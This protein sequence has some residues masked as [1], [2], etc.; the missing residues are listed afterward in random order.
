MSHVLAIDQ[1][2]SGTKAVLFDTL[3]AVVD[4]ATREHEQIYPQPGWVEHDA[5]AI[6]KNTLA[7]VAEVAERRQASIGDIAGVSI[8]N[9]R[10]T[11]VVF[12]RRTGQPL[13]NAIVWQCRRSDAICRDMIDAGCEQTIRQKTGLRL[14]AYFSASKLKWLLDAEPELRQR[15][16]SGEA[17]FGTIDTYLI[18]RLTRGAVYATD[19]TNASRTLLYDTS[20]LCWSSALCEEFSVP[21][22]R[23]P[24]VRE[25]SAHFGVTDA[26]GVFP[27]PVPICGVMG[28][29]QAALFAQRCFHPGMAKATFGSGTSV[30]LNIGDERPQ[31]S[32]DSLTALATVIDGRP[33]YALEGLINFSAA[34]ISWLKNQLGLIVDAHETERLAGAVEDNG[35][36]YLVPAF[37]G[38][39]APHWSPTAR[40]AIIGLSAHSRKEHVVRAALESI[41]YQVRDVLEMMRTDAGVE[42]Q[43]LFAD[44][45]PTRNGLLMQFVADVA[46]I[47]LAVAEAPEASALGAAMAGMLG[48]GI[49]GSLQELESLPREVRTFCPQ[50]ERGQVD[51]L[52]AGWSTA[53]GRVL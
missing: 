28:D 24:E 52:V 25:S 4:K 41:A 5:E 53:V 42:P 27:Q 6:W 32:S 49:Y 35:G 39:S 38:L 48:L 3:G 2:T 14:D 11:F 17:L 36:V 51:R 43:V 21:R 44:G 33:T 15:I 10:E 31:G 8:S 40:A 1:S 13:H 7:V 23:L 37:A 16:E 50:M 26:D 19:P 34:T 30:L 20:A 22:S 18:Y 12:D 46:Q 47:E 29:S 45:E 9:Q